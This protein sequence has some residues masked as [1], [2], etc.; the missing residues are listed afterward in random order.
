[1]DDVAQ[2]N[3]WATEGL[4]P[5]LTVVLDVD[6]VVSAQR[7]AARDGGAAGDRIESADVAFHTALREAFLDR[8]AAAPDRYLVL[9]GTAA[10]ESIHQAV[11]DHIEPMLGHGGSSP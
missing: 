8:A 7:R 9:D 11:R 5:D 3:E 10:V 2:V 4:E 6:P 1:M